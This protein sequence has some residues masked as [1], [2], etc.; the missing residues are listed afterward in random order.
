MGDIEF[1]QGGL[2]AFV[3]NDI[4]SSVLRIMK[5]KNLFPRGKMFQHKKNNFNEI[6]SSQI[7][8][9]AKEIATYLKASTA[10]LHLQISSSFSCI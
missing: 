6:Y 4:F 8:K 9:S 10:H 2:D 7:K 3:K 1:W 5:S